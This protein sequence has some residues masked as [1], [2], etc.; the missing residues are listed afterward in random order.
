MTLTGKLNH[1]VRTVGPAFFPADVLEP[2]P[3][4]GD[5]QNR[6]VT[7]ERF[8]KLEKELVR[9]KAELVRYC[10]HDMYISVHELTMSCS[11]NACNSYPQLSHRSTGCTQ[12]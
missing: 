4:S 2:T 6:D 1:L 3:A 11:Q 5:N 10:H 8:L 7:P 9:G 12:N